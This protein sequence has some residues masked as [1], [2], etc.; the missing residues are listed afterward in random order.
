MSVIWSQMFLPGPTLT[1]QN[2]PNQ[3]G[4]VFIVT[5][6]VSGVGLKLAT[7]LFQAGGK[8]Y[9]A[10]R[11]KDNAQ[12]AIQLIKSSVHDTSSA[13]QLEYL[14]LDYSDLSTNQSLGQN[15][16]KQ[17]IETRPSLDQRRCLFTSNRQRLEAGA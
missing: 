1:E 8:L 10:G 14:P 15:L 2:L 5:G 3:K 12:Q 7:F 11:S 17:R 6:G 4:K 16:Q 9:I 13:G